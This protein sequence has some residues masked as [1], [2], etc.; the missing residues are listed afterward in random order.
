MDT[1]WDKYHST[2]DEC[3]RMSQASFS[4]KIGSTERGTGKGDS[5][6]SVQ[7]LSASENEWTL[8]WKIEHHVRT[9]GYY[10]VLGDCT[11]GQRRYTTYEYRV[12]FLNPGE[13]HFPADEHGMFT[14]Y[15]VTFAVLALYAAFVSSASHSPSSRTAVGLLASAYVMQLLALVLEIVHLGYYEANGYGMFA[16]DFLSSVLEGLTMLVLTYLLVAMA[17][18]WS[19]VQG[20][21][22]QSSALNPDALGDDSVATSFLF[23]MAML[24]FV[25]Q[26][27]NKII[28]HDDFTKFHDYESLPGKFSVMV[29]VILATVFSIRVKQTIDYQSRRGGGRALLFLRWLALLGGLWVWSFPLLVIVAGLFAHYL[30]HR[31]VAGGV[32]VL[33]SGCLILLTR[34]VTRES[35]LYSQASGAS[36]GSLLPG[37][38]GYA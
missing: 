4:A 18:G 9:Y 1:E 23:C 13:D 38:L 26:L 37:S 8:S 19:L 7:Q 34:Q 17:S 32:L 15:L 35:S 25:L 29:H 30:R 20:L 14:L 3:Q 12:E 21:L 24:S 5:V 11:P 6:A 16:F 33:Q 31:V 27:L 28:V 22:G 2:T 36:A 10:V